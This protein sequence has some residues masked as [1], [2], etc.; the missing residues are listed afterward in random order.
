MKILLCFYYDN[1][2]STKLLSCTLA[3]SA[4]IR[5]ILTKISNRS[6]ITVQWNVGFRFVGNVT[7]VSF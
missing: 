2:A 4:T 1:G 6:G 3:I 7:S 5:R